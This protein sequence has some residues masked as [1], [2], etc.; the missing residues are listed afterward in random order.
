MANDLI[1]IS[2]HLVESCGLSAAV[3][4]C[5]TAQGFNMRFVQ[6][7]EAYPQPGDEL[8]DVLLLEPSVFHW[9]WLA[10]LLRFTT[11]LAHIPVVL[12]STHATP[13]DS[14]HR[15][16]EQRSVWLVNELPGLKRVLRDIRNGVKPQL[17][18]ILFVD[19]D[20]SVLNAYGRMLRK[21]PWK[22]LKSVS[23]E[24]ALGLIDHTEVDLIVTDIKMP[25]MHGMEL[26]Q[27]IRSRN[28]TV[29]IVVS[30]GYPGMKEDVDLKFNGVQA[31][32]PKPIDEVQLHCE[33]ERILGE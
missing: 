24:Q 13:E 5:A 17:K 26:I 9:E 18:T 28:K 7:I 15:W 29:P 19:D 23:G 3:E 32:L 21:S 12:F 22:V 25:E 31:F 6:H 11:Q 1:I 2:P 4:Q 30:S 14:L 10:A 8:P 33:L 20:E 27:R 16:C